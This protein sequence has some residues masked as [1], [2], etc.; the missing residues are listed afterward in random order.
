M[1]VVFNLLD[2]RLGLW[3]GSCL[4]PDRDVLST[5]ITVGY[6]V[7]IA[8]PIR[9]RDIYGDPSL[10]AGAFATN[11]SYPHYFELKKKGPKPLS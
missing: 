10:W 5:P 11:T 9:Q 3:N 4:L 6:L 8:H 7:A 2:N 1:D